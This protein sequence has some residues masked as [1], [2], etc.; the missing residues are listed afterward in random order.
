MPNLVA[1]LADAMAPAIEAKKISLSLSLARFY[2]AS[3]TVPPLPPPPSQL[4]PC[5][6]NFWRKVYSATRRRLI[7]LYD[8]EHQHRQSK[9]LIKSGPWTEIG[10]AYWT[11]KRTTEAAQLQ[12]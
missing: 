1:R 5:H 12:L 4:V 9:F 6:T 10:C 11:L 2:L 3:K 7:S 8:K